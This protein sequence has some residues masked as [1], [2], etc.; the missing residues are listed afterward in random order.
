MGRCAA[1]Q[2]SGDCT[3]RLLTK[4]EVCA[5]VGFSRAHVDRLTNDPAYAHY[6]FPKPTRIGVKVLWSEA[7]IDEWIV[8]QLARR[9]AS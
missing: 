4:K 9:E 1:L 7:E 5:K 3:M 6:G 8:A 2:L